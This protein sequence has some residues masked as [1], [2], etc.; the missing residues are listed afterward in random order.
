MDRIIMTSLNTILAVVLLKTDPL[1]FD[2]NS[3]PMRY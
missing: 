2:I 1:L 3:Y